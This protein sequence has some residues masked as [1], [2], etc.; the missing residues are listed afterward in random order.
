MHTLILDVSI[1]IN[2]KIVLFNLKKK[3]LP[4]VY[5]YCKFYILNH[6]F[7]LGR[8]LG[9]IWVLEQVLTLPLML[10]HGDFSERITAL[11]Q[12]SCNPSSPKISLGCEKNHHVHEI[13]LSANNKY[14]H[15]FLICSDISYKAIKH[16]S[17]VTPLLP[18]WNYH[19]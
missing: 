6:F 13:L 1:R 9:E 4:T 2:N 19:K 10:T 7:F 14:Y 18:F 8:L 5:D 12:Q 15:Y 16:Q 17:E 11:P 3:I